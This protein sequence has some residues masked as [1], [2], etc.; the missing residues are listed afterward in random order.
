LVFVHGK[1]SNEMENNKI[2]ALFIQQWQ[3]KKH[4]FNKTTRFFEVSLG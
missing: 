2:T 1:A 4:K 3:G